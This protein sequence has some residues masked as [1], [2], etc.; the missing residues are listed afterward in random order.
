MIRRPPR[1]TLFPY[2]T[3]FRSEDAVAGAEDHP[4][5]YRDR[6]QLVQPGLAQPGYPEIEQLPDR[7]LRTGYLERP[8]PPVDVGGG[9]PGTGGPAVP[10]VPRRVQGAGA[11]RQPQD[12]R[13]VRVDGQ[14]TRRAALPGTGGERVAV[15]EEEAAD[16][17]RGAQGRLGGDGGTAGVR[18][19]HRPV[20]PERVEE[21]EQ[22]PYLVVEVRPPDPP[23][24]APAD[25]VQRVD[26]VSRGQQ[27]ADP[28]P[29]VRGLGGAVHEYHG[30]TARAPLPVP[31]LGVA[32]R[33]EAQPGRQA[34]PLR[35]AHVVDDAERRHHDH[36][37][38][39][40][41]AETAQPAAPPRPA[42]RGGGGY[43]SRITSGISRSAFAWYWLYSGKIP[44]LSSHSGGFSL[45]L[46]VSDMTPK[47]ARHP[48]PT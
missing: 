11:D 39:H 33:D 25:Q 32:G 2:T 21:R 28:R 30:R 18:G 3:L 12:R 36:Q 27:G 44:V 7:V 13:P 24:V 17:S 47:R 9:E 15:E 1:S 40:R 48:S 5:G 37:G 38:Q 4:L 35:G 19:Q 42:R 45:A 6:G 10:G 20:D 34:R 41:H 31:G 22:L 16:A 8:A 46:Q 26:A 14:E 29:G 23:R 43:R